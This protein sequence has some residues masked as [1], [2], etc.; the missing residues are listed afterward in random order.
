MAK[1][2][3]QLK[4]NADD[5]ASASAGGLKTVAHTADLTGKGTSDSPLGVAAT[6]AKKPIFPT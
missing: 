6:I 1:I 3:T 4:K 2:D 5:I